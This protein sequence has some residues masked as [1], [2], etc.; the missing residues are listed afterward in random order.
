VGATGV[1][2]LGWRRAAEGMAQRPSPPGRD[3]L[4]S[5]HHVCER[6]GCHATRLEPSSGGEGATPLSA[7]PST[8]RAGAQRVWAPQPSRYSIGA[9]LLKGGRNAAARR[10]EPGLGR[11]PTCVGA[12]AVKL[13]GWCRAA[14]GRA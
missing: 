4:V 3:R 7:G 10:A 9:Q 6:H 12:A 5:G 11:G 14:E 13:L 2:L 8:A 1:T